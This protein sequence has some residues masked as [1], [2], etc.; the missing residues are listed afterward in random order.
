MDLLTEILRGMRDTADFEE[1]DPDDVIPA[2][3]AQLM[4]HAGS[5]QD[6][7]CDKVL[8]AIQEADRDQRTSSRTTKFRHSDGRIQSIDLNKNFKESYR[9][10]YTSEILPH[11]LLKDAMLDELK[12]FNDKVWVGVPLTQAQADPAG[13]IVGGSLGVV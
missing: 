11:S 12:Y 10:E 3:V 7:P 4:A 13:K 9:D 6:I 1:Q 8:A 5:M 2:D